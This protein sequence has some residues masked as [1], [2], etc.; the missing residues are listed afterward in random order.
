MYTRARPL[1]Q[2]PSLWLTRVTFAVVCFLSLVGTI[3]GNSH[4]QT[5]NQTIINASHTGA[6]TVVSSH[7]ACAVTEDSPG[8]CYSLITAG[9]EGKCEREPKYNAER[10]VLTVG[11]KVENLSA[12]STIAGEVIWGS[13]VY[14]DWKDGSDTEGEGSVHKPY[15]S[16]PKALSESDNGTVI[17]LTEGDYHENETILIDHTVGIR[18]GM[19]WAKDGDIW[20]AS[21]P[22]RYSNVHVHASPGVRI[23]GTFR[24]S[25]LLLNIT[26]TNP[27]QNGTVIGLLAA[28]ADSLRVEKCI[29]SSADAANGTD[30]ALLMPNQTSA[31]SGGRGMDGNPGCES[32]PHIVGWGCRSC[33]RPHGGR[34]GWGC[35]GN[36]GGMGGRASRDGTGSN[37]DSGQLKGT[38]GLGGPGVPPN[39]GD[40][41]IQMRYWGKDGH[42]GVKGV[43]ANS[44]TVAYDLFTFEGVA[45]PQPTRGSDGSAGSGGGGGGGG[46]GSPTLQLC[47]SFGS[48]GGGGGGGGCGG[49]GGW[50]GGMGG[51][52]ITIYLYHSPRVVIQDCELRPGRA[53]EGGKGSPGMKG[54]TGGRGGLYVYGLDGQQQASNGGQGGKGGDGGDGGAGSDGHIGGSVGVLSVGLS[55]CVRSDEGISV[56]VDI[57]R[58]TLICTDVFHVK[59]VNTSVEI[60][61]PTFARNE[62]EDV[63]T[64]GANDDVGLDKSDCVMVTKECGIETSRCIEWDIHSTGRTKAKFTSNE[65]FKVR[66]VPQSTILLACGKSKRTCTFVNIC[67]ECGICGGDGASCAGCENLA[68]SSSKSTSMA[69]A[70]LDVCGVCG[71]AGQ[72]CEGCD[73]RNGSNLALD[74][75]GVCG[76]DGRSCVELKLLVVGESRQL[77]EAE[78]GNIS[79]N[80]AETVTFS[81]QF[82]SIP[83]YD[84]IVECLTDARTVALVRI[85][86]SILVRATEPTNPLFQ[87]ELLRDGKTNLTCTAH[88]PI[89]MEYSG[90][91]ASAVVNVAP[92]HG[93]AS[94][95]NDGEN[96]GEFDTATESTDHSG[97]NTQTHI[98]T[99]TSNG[100][101]STDE[102]GGSESAAL[103]LVW[104]IVGVGALLTAICSCS[105]ALLR[106]NCAY[107]L[108]RVKDDRQS[109]DLFE[110]TEP[111]GTRWS[112]GSSNSDSYE[113][114]ACGEDD[115]DDFK[116]SKPITLHEEVN[117]QH[118]YHRPSTQTHTHTHVHAH[119]DM[120]E[121]HDSCGSE[122]TPL[123]ENECVSVE[124]NR[125]STYVYEIDDNDDDDDDSISRSIGK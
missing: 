31:I 76:G 59:G 46:G 85:P 107:T 83:S 37:G 6:T 64:A 74:I 54:G 90:V 108:M 57:N 78:T 52:S 111:H 17:Y 44:S 103:I 117:H 123:F 1:F 10:N 82:G 28:A 112:N 30:G 89:Q 98:N 91:S 27:D 109:S 66:P 100:I 58:P 4:T 87:L 86:Q 102:D 88:A 18:G 8:W 48:G 81:V 13:I 38:G 84:V 73:G 105:I 119:S 113:K 11:R 79:G 41:V 104:A 29:I 25:L 99:N 77:S 5:S 60:D 45:H 106:R 35:E 36:S 118:T 42:P 39:K 32:G 24:T 14:V 16:L 63:P 7:A 94:S 47:P 19:V 53:G 49:V 20:S 67:D 12:S 55:E 69:L 23:K 33:D 72:T 15:R 124:G 95:T 40:S 114:M 50:S 3:N 34:G 92:A 116:N 2:S 96:T 121:Q 80:M 56:G 125:A 22:L 110:L 65:T 21:R 75:C 93:T 101:S 68:E 70:V 61:L 115:D 71:G 122:S 9:K 62:S 97:N 43:N 26:V 51:S 120:Q